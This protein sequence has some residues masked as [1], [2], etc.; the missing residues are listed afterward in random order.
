MSHSIGTLRKLGRVLIDF[1]GVVDVVYRFF[2]RTVK[3]I[4]FPKFY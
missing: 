4:A 1:G 2:E 3:A